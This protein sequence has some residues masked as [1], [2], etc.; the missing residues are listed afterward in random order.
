MQ[1]ETLF[2]R[3]ET[4]GR[5]DGNLSSGIGLSLV[6]ELVQLLHGTIRVESVPGKGSSFHVSLPTGYDVF[7][8]DKN[9]E[10]ILNDSTRTTVDQDVQEPSA[11][12]N[13]PEEKDLSVLVV[14]DNDYL[15]K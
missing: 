7:R 11:D 2:Q 3:F 5:K 1:I 8:E 9:V 14:E 15:I 10:F 4:L 12:E 13:T 6:H